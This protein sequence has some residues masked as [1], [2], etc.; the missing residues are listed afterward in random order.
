MQMNQASFL[1]LMG[2]VSFPMDWPHLSEPQFHR[3]EKEMW[4]HNISD[5]T[6]LLGRNM[7][8]KLQRAP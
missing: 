3:V 4:T 6:K 7:I 5:F 1:F 2:C 8:S